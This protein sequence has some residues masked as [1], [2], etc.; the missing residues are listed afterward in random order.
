MARERYITPLRCRTCGI[1][2]DAAM[3]DRKS[4]MIEPDYGT[5]VDAVPK[6]F[7]IVQIATIPYPKYDVLCAKFHESALPAGSK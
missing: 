1:T 7:E 5:T 2:G 4:Y 6:G 3:S